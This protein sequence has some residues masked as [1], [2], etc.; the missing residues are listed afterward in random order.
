MTNAAT[1]EINDRKGWRVALGYALCG[2][3]V[4]ERQ[5]TLFDEMVTNERKCIF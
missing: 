4:V 2:N 5:M 3:P 1:G